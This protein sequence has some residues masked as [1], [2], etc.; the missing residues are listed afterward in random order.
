MVNP[1][2][3]EEYFE[4]HAKEI[5]EK[6]CLRTGRTYDFV[7]TLR[8]GTVFSHL[9][10]TIYNHY[11]GTDA[12]ICF[13]DWAE[14]NKIHCDPIPEYESNDK[15]KSPYYNP[16]NRVD[17]RLN[18]GKYLSILEELIRPKRK[19]VTGRYPVVRL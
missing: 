5:V 14:A 19:P 6:Y 16:T 15:V 17:D 13:R 9:M 4:T 2:D 11:V 10:I 3:R 8:I 1:S 18:F 12:L 7:S